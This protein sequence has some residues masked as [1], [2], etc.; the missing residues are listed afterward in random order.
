MYQYWTDY[1]QIFW[2]RNVATSLKTKKLKFGPSQ[3]K[4]DTIVELSNV[5][6]GR[7]MQIMSWWGENGKIFL[8]TEGTEGEFHFGFCVQILFPMVLQSNMSNTSFSYQNTMLRHTF[9]KYTSLLFSLFFILSRSKILSL[10]SICWSKTYI[11]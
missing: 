5:Q 3:E 9:T 1:F 11:P 2:H 10:E 7:L 4:L 6:V 8:W